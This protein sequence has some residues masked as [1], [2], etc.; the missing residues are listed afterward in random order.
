MTRSVEGAALRCLLPG[1]VGTSAPDWVLR[2]AADG[3]GGVCLYARNITSPDQLEKLCRRLHAE[4]PGLIIAIDEEGG[5]VTRL[6]AATGSSYPGNLALGAAGD[7]DLTRS[8]ARAIGL[9]LATAGIDLDLAPDADVNSNAANPVIGVRSF[10]SEPGAVAAHTAAWIHGLQSAGVAA[11]V[12]HFPGHGDTSVDSHVALPVVGADP[13]DGALR[14][15]EA[16]IAAGV[17]AVMSAHIVAPSLGRLPA[18]VSRPIMTGLLREELG[19]RGLSVTDG[20]EMKA[21]AD[22]S[23]G[24]VQSLEAGCDLLCIGGGL[25]DEDVVIELHRAIVAAV[26]GARLQEAADRV[27]ALAEWRAAHPAPADA[28]DRTVGLAAAR[29][30]LRVEGDLRV[31][32]DVVV[33]QLS[34]ESSMASGLIPWG[35]AEPL[36]GRGARVTKFEYSDGP[37][38]LDPIARKA[39]GRSLVVTVRNLHRHEWQQEAA[40]ALLG[41]RPDSVVVEMGLPACRPAGATRYITTSGAARVC[42]IAAAEVMRP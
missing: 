9:E 28:P 41:M 16:A 29:R 2:R 13:R 21:I 7:V 19:F 20:L 14:P 33:V 36:A 15:F 4:N 12:K 26:S 5:D 22:I 23:A 8:V 34:P 31:G 10:G 39:G 32:D 42:A 38:D 25:A 1:F 6:E 24:A 37:I 40:A 35:L 27:D 3:L 18:T 11:C 17:R 30:A